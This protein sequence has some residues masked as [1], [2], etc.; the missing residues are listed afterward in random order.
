MP[1]FCFVQ[2]LETNLSAVRKYLRW[3]DHRL[4]VMLFFTFAA[5]GLIYSPIWLA[6]GFIL[7]GLWD[8]LHHPKMITTKIKLSGSHL[9]APYSI[10]L[11]LYS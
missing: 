6:I 5:L 3:Q 8:T 7:H 11:L 10:L 4:R 1:A 2:I 9:Y